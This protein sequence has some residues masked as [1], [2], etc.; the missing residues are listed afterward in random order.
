LSASPLQRRIVLVIPISAVLIAGLMAYKMTRRYEPPVESNAGESNE[1]EGRPA[2]LFSIEDQHS[3]MVRLKSYVGRQKLLIV[4]FDGS[5]GP[6]HSE[7]LTRL[8]AAFPELHA[9]GAV[10]LAISASRPSQNRYGAHLE[11]LKA[12]TQGSAATEQ[13]ELRYPFLLLSDILDYNVHRMYQA[14]DERT[15]QPLEAVF[16]VDR[17]GLIQ[18]AHFGPDHMGTAAEWIKDLQDVR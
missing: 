8:K 13:D 18:F 16:V 11:H 6:D 3:R 9:T 15:G 2:P 17:A 12:N 1:F 14:F 5:Q 4:F 7:L 10:V